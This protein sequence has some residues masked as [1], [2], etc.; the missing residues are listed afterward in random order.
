MGSCQADHAEKTLWNSV[1]FVTRAVDD[2]KSADI[3]YLDFTKAFHKV[4]RKSRGLY[5]GKYTPPWGGGISADVIW[6][7]KY[8]K[9]KRKKGKM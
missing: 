9:A 3:F 6:G 1:D 7:K 5:F 8:E 2:R 4:P